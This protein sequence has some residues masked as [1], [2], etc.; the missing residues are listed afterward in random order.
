MNDFRSWY[1]GLQKPTW[2]PDPSVIGTVWTI[3]YPIIFA[4]NVYVWSL[5]ARGTISG[6]VLVPFAL[7]LIAN[8]IFTPIQ[9]G[10]R[11]LWLAAVVIIVVWATTIW[12]IIAIWPH[13]KIAAYAFIPYLL[14]VSVA[15]V[16]Q[17]S[18]SLKNS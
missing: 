17:L 10:L 11:N 7:N 1:D 9:F 2:T 18:I 12:C 8:I 6:W 14:W 4:L 13:S 15:S 5:F 16:L 3:L